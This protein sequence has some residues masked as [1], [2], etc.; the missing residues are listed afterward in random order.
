MKFRQTLFAF[1][2]LLCWHDIP[3]KA[4]NQNSADLCSPN[5]SNVTGPITFNCNLNR[6][7]NEP[8]HRVPPVIGPNIQTVDLTNRYAT[9]NAFLDI[10]NIRE[11][12]SDFFLGKPCT[13]N[14]S[15]PIGTGFSVAYAVISDRGSIIKRSLIGTQPRVASLQLPEG[16]YRFILAV[17][18]DAGYYSAT[19]QSYCG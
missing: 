17:I 18:R 4:Q 9:V 10:R 19:I 5:F 3:A 1:S 16:K 8:G 7:G 14:I 15:L 11:V 13:V 12:Y 6:G 2:A